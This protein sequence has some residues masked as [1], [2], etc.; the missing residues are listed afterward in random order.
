MKLGFL[1]FRENAKA[2]SYASI[3]DSGA[4]VF[5]NFAGIDIQDFL[6]G[7]PDLCYEDLILSASGSDIL[8]LELSSGYSVRIPTGIKLL[9]PQ[10]I[11]TQTFSV[12]SETDE[13]P[14]VEIS[15]RVALQVRPKSGRAYKECLTITNSP[16]TVDNGYTGELM[17][18]ITNLTT[19]DCVDSVQIHSGEKIAQVVLE[20]IPNLGDWEEI[21]E[22][23]LEQVESQRGDGGFGSTGV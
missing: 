1:P 4:D 19:P 17:I 11:L 13:G 6:N 12:T 23:D 20:L 8:G 18:L 5:A 14:T 22:A 7:N 15:F 2:P 21:S 16:G 9:L 3:Q 10:D